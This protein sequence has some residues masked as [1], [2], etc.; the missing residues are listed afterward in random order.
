MTIYVAAIKGR[1]IATFEAENDMAAEIRVHDRMFRDDLMVLATDGVPL[2]DGGTKIDIRQAFPNE[3]AKWRASRA[4]AVRHGN[5]EETDEAWIS[6]LV[7][8]T[9]FDRDTR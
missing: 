4:R 3:E 2:W 1:G 9:D 6:F 7:A 5:I 8:L